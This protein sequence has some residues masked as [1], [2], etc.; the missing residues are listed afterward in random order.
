MK[1]KNQKST[2]VPRIRLEVIK[3]VEIVKPQEKEKRLQIWRLSD[4]SIGDIMVMEIFGRTFTSTSFGSL[5]V[6]DEKDTL[7]FQGPKKN[8]YITYK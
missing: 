4:S 7:L 8:F 5:M 1:K 6:E 3:K 2:G